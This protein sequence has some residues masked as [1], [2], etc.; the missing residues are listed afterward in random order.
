MCTLPSRVLVPLMAIC[1]LVSCVAR[2]ASEQEQEREVM[3]ALDAFYGGIRSGDA[4][5]T[6]A[7]VAPGALF[8]ESGRLETREEYET[9]H[10]PADIAFEKQVTG[11]RMV[12][13]VA[14]D[15]ATAWVV[16]MTEYDGTFDGS[17]VSF[18]SAQ[19]AVLG[20][21]ENGWQIRSIHWSSRRN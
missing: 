10:L 3:A 13:R 9:N 18:V 20:R 17:P 1:C 6:M 19:L 5:A 16:A 11:E 15:G 12:Q 14:I 4:A 7:V 21:A 8:V 2:P